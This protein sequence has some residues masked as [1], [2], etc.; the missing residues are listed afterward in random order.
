VKR[1]E[2]TKKASC[3]ELEDREFGGLDWI[4]LYLVGVP[5]TYRGGAMTPR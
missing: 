1:G 2:A 3:R 5:R 4:V